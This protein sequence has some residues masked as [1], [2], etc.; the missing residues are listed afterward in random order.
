MALGKNLRKRKLIGDEAEKSSNKKEST[1]KKVK[2]PDVK[3]KLIPTPKAKTKKQSAV[4]KQPSKP[5][6][7]EI[8]QQE[9]PFD[10]LSI[11]IANELRERKNK[12]REKYTEE[13]AQM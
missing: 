12:L 2:K 13:I 5:P 9:Q 10:A 11:Y 8:V 7:K 1:P 4:K 3:E 6:K